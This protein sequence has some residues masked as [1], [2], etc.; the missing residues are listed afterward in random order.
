VADEAEAAIAY[1]AAGFRFRHRAFENSRL[2]HYRNS[3]SNRANS[4]PRGMELVS[5]F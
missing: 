3:L 2:G 5:S 1:L 4:P